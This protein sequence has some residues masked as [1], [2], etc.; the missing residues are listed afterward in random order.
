MT[1]KTLDEAWETTKGNVCTATL[2]EIT[3][4]VKMQ[5]HAFVAKTSKKYP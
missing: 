1:I 4:S 2:E 3:Q 5:N